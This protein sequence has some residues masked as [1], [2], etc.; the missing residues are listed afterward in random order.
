M[1]R[2]KKNGV[3][4]WTAGHSPAWAA[5][6]A[7]GISALTASA[8][9]LAGAPASIGIAEGAVGAAASLAVS[10]ARKYTGGHRA[11]RCAAWL[12]AGG[13]C[14]W[15]LA[16]GPWSSW[17]HITALVGGTI[18]AW[19]ANAAWAEWELDAPERRREAELRA[20]R[21]QQAGDW[22]DRLERVCRISGAQ[23]LAVE[24]WEADAGYTVEVQLPQG[25]ATVEDI[26]RY[27]DSLRADLRLP[28]GCSLEITKGSTHGT[29]LIAV[30]TVNMLARLLPYPVEET[31]DPTDP[32]PERTIN[33]PL[34]IGRYRD[35]QRAQGVLRAH[36]GLLIG[37]PE[38]GKTNL[39]HALNAELARCPDVLIW[40]IDITGA[41]LTM[42]WLRAWAREGTAPRPVV[43]WSASTVEEALAMLRVAAQIIE[44]RKRDYQ[45]LMYEVNDDK[46]PVSP[47][48]PAIIIISD[49]IAE[50]PQSIQSGL[51]KVNNTGRASAVRTFNCA[52]RGTRDMVSASQKEMTRWRIGMRVSDSSEYQHLFSDYRNVD[53]ADAQ[54]KGSGFMEWDGSKPRPFKAYRIKPEEIS[55]VSVMTA[56]IRPTLDDISLGIDDAAVYRDRWARTLPHLFNLEKVILAPAA[57][58]LLSD[59][60]TP[61]PA[62]G[63]STTPAAPARD[64][65]IDMD[66]LFPAA[67]PPEYNGGPAA[68]RHEMKDD[69]DQRPGTDPETR[70]RLDKVLSD[71]DRPTPAPDPGDAAPRPTLA[72]VPRQPADP[73]QTVTDPSQRRALELLRAARTDGL[74]ATRLH[75]ML[76]EEGHPTSRPTAQEWLSRWTSKGWLAKLQRDGGR[77]AYVLAEYGDI[78]PGD[79]V[80]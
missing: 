17:W 44:T 9:H 56:E 21:E 80:A 54:E 51:D 68:P 45:E 34:Y 2:K 3:L 72:A 14:S 25:G 7:A 22:I 71:A 16:A 39:L 53:A 30:N 61:V 11:Y 33:G 13:W 55:T 18:L 75:E 57:R 73:T 40:H 32:R 29:A 35:G 65:G 46:I 67:V 1:S 48:V 63:E 50:L 62:T 36:C 74:G 41:G 42:P 77:V 49:E 58:E 6:N 19:G 79:R 24:T 12:A 47:S 31:D 15:S 76:R 10:T 60:P 26:A 69:Q 38:G 64:D 59:A 43:D 52:L 28:V 37:Q 5:I 70:Q 27:T 4:D 66:A 8:G 20:R 78:A 23:V